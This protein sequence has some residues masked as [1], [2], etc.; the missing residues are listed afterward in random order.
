MIDELHEAAHRGV[1]V[2]TC[3]MAALLS[4]C[5]AGPPEPAATA[6]LITSAPMINPDRDGVAKPVMVRIYQLKT[7][8]TFETADF[9]ALQGDPAAVLGPD[10]L[11]SED[12]VVR[13]ASK[14]SFESSLDPMARFVGVTAAFRDIDNAQ[15]RA[16]VELPEEKLIKFL[17]KR[18]MLVGVDDRS[19]TLKF[20]KPPK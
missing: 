12:M 6:G 8:G 20:D 16:L 1:L 17:D 7:A 5:A 4:A 14:L 15:W 19:V 2:A 3:L 18:Q 13:P 11:A 10:L 9:F